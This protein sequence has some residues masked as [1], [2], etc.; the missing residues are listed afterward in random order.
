MDGINARD[1]AM[2]LVGQREGLHLSSVLHEL[3]TAAGENIDEIEGDQSGVRLQEG[4]LWETAA[5][6]MMAGLDFDE[7]IRLAFKRYML[8][9]RAGVVSQVHLER[10]GVRMTP[11]AQDIAARRLES[12]KVTRRTLRKARTMEDFEEHHW[13]WCMQ[14]MAYLLAAGL[15]TVRWIVWWVAGDYAKGKGS[16]PRVLECT[17][18][19]SQEEMERNWESVMMVARRMGH[20]R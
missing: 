6:Y 7:A 9:L 3:K 1:A 20:V 15:D 14:E 12:Y 17:A 18:R 8:H 11:D 19:F 16:G 2:G 13:V 10:D 4:F 5:E